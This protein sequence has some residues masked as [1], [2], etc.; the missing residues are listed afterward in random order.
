MSTTLRRRSTSSSPGHPVSSD[1]SSPS[2]KRRTMLPTIKNKEFAGSSTTEESS[3][4]HSL[5]VGCNTAEAAWRVGMCDSLTAFFSA[6]YV[7]SSINPSPCSWINVF[8]VEHIRMKAPREADWWKDVDERS[9]DATTEED[10]WPLNSSGVSNESLDDSIAE[11]KRATEEGDSNSNSTGN[12]KKFHNCGLETWEVAR[13]AWTARSACA[14]D[15]GTGNR[16]RSSS[17]MSI[18]RSQ[19]PPSKKELSRMLAKASTLRTCELPRR[20]PLKNL[21][22]AYVI[23]WNGS[24]DI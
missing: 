12:A 3:C 4:H 5:T 7:I 22:E 16:A 1:V 6:I 15:K 17:L 10:T 9:M 13:A 20:T 23:V 14:G 21:V 24:A 11:S 18:T 8:R 19:Q 2:R